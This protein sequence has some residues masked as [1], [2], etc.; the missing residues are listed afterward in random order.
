M[1]YDLF[2]ILIVVA[3]IML[4]IR[5]IY[6]VFSGKGDP[7]GCGS[8]DKCPGCGFS[9]SSNCAEGEEYWNFTK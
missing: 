5:R 2:V 8:I 1:L 4:V 9:E 3:A 6:K 7:C